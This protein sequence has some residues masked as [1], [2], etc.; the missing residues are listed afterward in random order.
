MSRIPYASAV[1]SSMYVMAAI[2]PDLA[3]VVGATCQYM[4]NP[5]KKHWEAIKHIFRYLRGTENLP[6]SKASQIL[7]MS[8]T[9]TIRN[10]H[11]GMSSSMEGECMILSTT[12]AEYIAALDATKEAIWLHRLTA[13][14]SAKSR[15]DHLARTL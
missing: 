5:E 12:K 3:Y 14:F 4:S 6:K 10:L 9:L 1:G 15:I 7:I 13:N 8:T 2:R 11:Q